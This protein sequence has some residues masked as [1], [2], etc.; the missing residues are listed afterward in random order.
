MT[1]LSWSSWASSSFRALIHHGP[2]PPAGH[3]EVRL[4]PLLPE[5][6]AMLCQ[7][8][9]NHQEE[10]MEEIEIRDL[11]PSGFKIPGDY[12]DEAEVLKLP[13]GTTEC[14]FRTPWLLGK[15]VRFRINLA[16]VYKELQK[17]EGNLTLSGREAERALEKVMHLV[18]SLKKETFR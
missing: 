9:G 1:R 7:V 10:A 15:K 5:P 2:E 14:R 3:L 17:P 18:K 11:S 16:V 4:E 12:G 6:L 8:A 13:D